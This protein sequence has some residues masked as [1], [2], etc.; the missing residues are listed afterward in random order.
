MGKTPFVGQTKKNETKFRTQIISGMRQDSRLE[1]RNNELSGKTI[2]EIR[3]VPISLEFQTSCMSLGTFGPMMTRTTHASC[4]YAR[5]HMTRNLYGCGFE[6]CILSIKHLISI[7]MNICSYSATQTNVN[8]LQKFKL[9]QNL[10]SMLLMW[11][12]QRGKRWTN[13]WIRWAGF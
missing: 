8:S 9:T 1:T 7:H 4:L 6:K 5:H 13:I 2:K 10:F 11:M 12:C 3:W